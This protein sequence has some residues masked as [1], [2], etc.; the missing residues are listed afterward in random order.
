MGMRLYELSLRAYPRP[1]R[2]E[3]GEAM[4]ETFAARRRERARGRGAGI[5]DTMLECLDVVAAG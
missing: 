4:R 3:H 2:R 1:F 5:A